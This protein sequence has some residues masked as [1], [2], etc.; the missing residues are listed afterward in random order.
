MIFQHH[1]EGK[2]KL[3]ATKKGSETQQ[4]EKVGNRHGAT[5]DECDGHQP[6]SQAPQYN[7]NLKM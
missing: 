5:G 3:W 4:T 2:G 1:S 6:Y 7:R